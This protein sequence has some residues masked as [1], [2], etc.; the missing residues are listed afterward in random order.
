VTQNLRS[1]TARDGRNKNYRS[2]RL[3]SK[4]E[5]EFGALESLET[6]KMENLDI[7]TKNKRICSEL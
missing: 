2:N 6:I 3:C 5:G 4:S 7:S 1:A